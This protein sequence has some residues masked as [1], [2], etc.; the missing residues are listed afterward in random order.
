VKS[1]SKASAFPPS[2]ASTK[3]ESSAPLMTFESV[4]AAADPVPTTFDEGAFWLFM[5][6]QKNDAQIHNF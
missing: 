3:L 4:P 5:I 1:C 2:D 6:S